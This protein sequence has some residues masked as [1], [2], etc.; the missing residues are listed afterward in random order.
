MHPSQKKTLVNGCSHTRALVPD[1]IDGPGWPEKLSLLLDKPILNLAEDGKANN[2]MIDECIRYLAYR[3][4]VDHIIIQLTQ[5]QRINLF[6]RTHSMQWES[7]DLSS[8]ILRLQEDWHHD[9]C[10][11][12]KL[13]GASPLDLQVTRN[14]V[15]KNDQQT[16]FIGDATFVH[17]QIICGTLMWA[18]WNLCA[19]RG[20][21]L[22][23]LTFHALGSRRTD[24]VWDLPE[25]CFLVRN[26]KTGLYNH[27]Q[28]KF[29]RPD[30]FHF[31]EKAHDYLAANL[32]ANYNKGTQMNIIQKDYDK[33]Y[34]IIPLDDIFDYSTI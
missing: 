28:W 25:E 33:E 23:V 13:P 2:Q 17:E 29:K 1:N 21:K 19:S 16:Y 4:D 3:D 24:P 8:Q 31:E 5:W 15:T 18:L 14:R 20:I 12:V 26:R 9:D 7:G 10:Q 22:T 30:T 11:Y 6:R 32:A 34:G 27:L